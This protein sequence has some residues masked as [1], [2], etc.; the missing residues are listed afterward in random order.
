MAEAGRILSGRTPNMDEAMA[1]MRRASQLDAPHN[2]GSRDREFYRLI[3][4]AVYRIDWRFNF[5][6][7]ASNHSV[8]VFL[9]EVSL[10]R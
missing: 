1:V 9:K 8:R 10:E 2:D 5:F 3:G 7:A 6:A 4:S